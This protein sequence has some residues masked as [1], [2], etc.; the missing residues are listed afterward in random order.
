MESNGR[1]KKRETQ[2]QVRKKRRERKKE[3]V[4]KETYKSEMKRPN[5]EPGEEKYKKEVG[6][7]A[8]AH[9]RGGIW[10]GGGGEAL[11]KKR[12]SKRTTQRNCEAHTAALLSTRCEREQRAGCVRR[13]GRRRG[14]ERE[15]VGE[16]IIQRGPQNRGRLGARGTTA[17][18][19]LGRSSTG[20][21]PQG[22]Y[23]T[24]SA[25]RFLP[26]GVG[27]SPTDQ[28]ERGKGQ[29]RREQASTKL[30]IRTG[31]REKK[32]QQG[33][34]G[35]ALRIPGACFLTMYY[36]DLCNNEGFFNTSLP[37]AHRS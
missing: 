35:R 10:R 34:E 3:Q 2:C 20:A 11:W 16:S 22:I 36:L 8:R 18:A 7:E 31:E 5:E 33:R 25:Q 32:E 26:A 9:R 14:A 1:D 23:T 4:P 30:L 24:T 12:K 19:P 6:Q 17:S 13:S 29:P 15:D 37:L 21:A 28:S 27:N